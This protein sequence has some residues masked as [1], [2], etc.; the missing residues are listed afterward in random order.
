MNKP[1]KILVTGGAGYIGSHT[2]VELIKAGYT[3]I[4]IDNLSNSDKSSLNGIKEIT[5][6]TPIFYEGDCC[7]Y[8]FMRNIFEKENISGAIHFAGYKAVGESI[9]KP[10]K[11][12]R[13]NIN[14]LLTLLDIIQKQKKNKVFPIIFSSSATV[15]GDANMMPL[16]EE[17][18]RKPATNPYGNTKAICEDILRD[19]VAAQNF[20]LHALA[21]RYFNPIGA[22]PTG[23]IGERPTGT[24]ANLVPYL[25]QAAAKKRAPLTVYGDDYATPDGTGIRDYIHV[26]DLAIAH[27]AALKYALQKKSRTF[28]IFNIGTGMGTSVKELIT[29]FKKETGV[30]VPHTIGPRRPG[31]IA[32]CYADT[33]RANEILNWHARYTVTDALRDAW[34]WEKKEYYKK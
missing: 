34:Q 20:P 17:T 3:P 28:D 29:T 11:Y 12:Y 26:V 2:A 18:P 31:D 1:T 4:I 25:T 16:T 10:L 24:P 7:D 33:T 8:D 22:H 6:T 13:N 14:S 27:I 21:L 19:T 9:E 30:H 23:H 32:T 5:G 15:Y